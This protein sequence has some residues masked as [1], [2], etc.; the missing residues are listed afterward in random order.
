MHSLQLLTYDHRVLLASIHDKG[1]CP[2]PCCLVPLNKVHNLGTT[3]DMKQNE[4]LACVDNVNHRN[5]VE[6]TRDIIYHKNYTVNNK[7][8]EAMLKEESYV[9]TKVGSRILFVIVITYHQLLRIHSLKSLALM[10]ST[11]LPCS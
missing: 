9:A 3:T 11:F 4:K 1:Q 7:A 8:S 5:K 10:D 6:T 2:C